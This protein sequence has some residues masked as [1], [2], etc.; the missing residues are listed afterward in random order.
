M[1]G[2]CGLVEGGMGADPDSGMMPD[3]VMM[4]DGGGMD[5]FMLPDAPMDIMT[6][7][8]GTGETEAGIACTCTPAI[9]AN[10]SVVELNAK[11][12]PACPMNWDTATNTIESP[13]GANA[14]CSCSCNSSPMTAPAC[15]GNVNFT[16]NFDKNSACGTVTQNLTANSTCTAGPFGPWTATANNLDN[17]SVSGNAPSPSGGQCGAV[18]V[19]KTVQPPTFDSG[20][21]CKPKVAP[22]SCG[23]TTACVPTV[24]SPE[25][26]CIAAA[27]VQVCPN[28]WPNTHFTAPSNASIVDGRMCSA[29]QGCSFSNMGTCSTP[30]LDLWRTSAICMGGAD[31]SLDG[32]C[33][34]VGYANGPVTY[35]AARYKSAPSGATCG[36][37]GT[38]TASGSVTLNPNNVTT[39]CCL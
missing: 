39:I 25:A 37:A 13:I 5:T 7:D 31:D 35:A 33:R 1:V 22:G 8:L 12:R 11:N 38:C 34:N 23:G 15:T 21:F 19:M 28:G 4:T 2:A 30:T 32:T 18:S 3:V 26:I 16:I 24:S 27:G 10:W 29:N 14:T 9:P 20:R 36:Y 17:A 6:P